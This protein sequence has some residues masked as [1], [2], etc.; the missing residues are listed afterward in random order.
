MTNREREFANLGL[1]YAEGI[2][3]AK[4]VIL[5]SGREVRKVAEGRWEA[6]P[7]NDNYWKSFDDCLEACKFAL[8]DFTPLSPVRPNLGPKNS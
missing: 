4:V 6:Q 2:E 1:H 3:Q 7:Y 5:P 8:K